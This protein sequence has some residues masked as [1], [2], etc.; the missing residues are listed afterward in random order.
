VDIAVA[1]HFGVEVAT[2][3]FADRAYLPDGRLA[4]RGDAGAVV[5]DADA[6]AARAVTLALE[7]RVAAL[8]GSWIPI[9]AASIC[10]HGDTAGAAELARQVRGALT[11]AGVTLQS[12]VT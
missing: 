3:A 8:D 5:T 12:F 6:A 10:V 1:E 7:H 11:A 2:E 9:T 4:P